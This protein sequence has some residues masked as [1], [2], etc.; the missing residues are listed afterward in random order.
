MTGRY[1][2][3]TG[4]YSLIGRK[5]APKPDS[6]QFDIGTAQITFADLVKP[7]GYTIALSGKWQLS[8][9]LPTLINDCGF[10]KYCMWA[11]AEDLPDDEENAAI[12]K[13]GK[14]TSRYW[15]PSI[16]KNA[17]V[18]PT[19]K[20]D[21]GPD[22]FNDFEI[23]FITK[24]KDKPFFL[25]CPMVLTHPPHEPTPDLKNPGKKTPEGMKSNVEYMDHL[26]G[27]LV[28]TITDLGL[29]DD[30]IIFFMGDN[31]TAK[32]GK[33]KT[34]ELGVRVPL[35]VSCPAMIQPDAVSDELVDFSDIFPTIAEFTGAELPKDREI[36][37]KS[38]AAVLRANPDKPAKGREWIFSYLNDERML[39]DKRWL[40]EGDGKFYDCGN[41]RDG[42]NYKDV[43]NSK[44]E[45]VITA[46]KRFDDILKK[47]P[48]PK[49]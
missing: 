9:K 19:T 47:L 15:Q 32:D 4:W 27:K 39:R 20:D 18:V 44:D 17:K 40:L 5:L 1:A 35:I 11:Y 42:K 14:K 2:F 25:Y 10:D 46:R 43:T 23:N 21:Y 45:E 30:T 41:N 31:G 34:T 6:P 24:H 16:M 28:Q 22:I 36:D 33:G 13:R 7:L 26:V 48:A 8:G 37:G 12:K 3:R 38:F 29:R 49:P